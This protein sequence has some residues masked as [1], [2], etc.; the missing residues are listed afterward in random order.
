MTTSMNQINDLEEPAILELL[1]A[2]FPSAVWRK[3]QTAEGGYVGKLP[4][5]KGDIRLCLKASDAAAEGSCLLLVRDKTEGNWLASAPEWVTIAQTAAF[6]T[7]GGGIRSAVEAAVAELH[8]QV[9]MIA[10]ALTGGLFGIQVQPVAVREGE[11]E[12]AEAEPSAQKDTGLS[13]SIR[14]EVHSDDYRYQVEF[15]A[16]K[17]FEQASDK[18]IMGLAQCGWGG[19]YAADAVAEYFEDT[20]EE[21]AQLM[22]Y[23]CA[24]TGSREPVGFE[25]KVNCDDAIAWLEQHRPDVWAKLRIDR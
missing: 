25:V 9:A 22:N 3:Q 13:N 11:S 10:D 7:D 12:P 2:Y 21:I 16:T 1:K 15:D 6:Q 18:E 8:R 17:W 4:I 23:C 14:A 20:L 19:D 5:Q 24:T